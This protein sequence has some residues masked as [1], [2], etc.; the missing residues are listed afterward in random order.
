MGELKISTFTAYFRADQNLCT[1][2]LISKIISCPV[3]RNQVHALVKSSRSYS[4]FVPDVSFKGYGSVGS[5]TDNQDFPRQFLQQGTSVLDDFCGCR[6][7]ASGPG[8]Q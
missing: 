5:G 2:F 8:G 7:C 4:G 6:G 3:S 1:A